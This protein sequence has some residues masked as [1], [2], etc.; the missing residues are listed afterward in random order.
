MVE[1]SSD[2]AEEKPTSW[3]LLLL[4]GIFMLVAAVVAYDFIDDRERAG[5]SFRINWIFAVVYQV[6]GK[7]GVSGLLAAFGLGCLVTSARRFPRA[8][9]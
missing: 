6:L 7:W 8:A 2:C 5:E 3:W 4:V 1:Q 9:G